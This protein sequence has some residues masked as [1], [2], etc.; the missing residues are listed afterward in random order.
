MTKEKLI[1]IIQRL[2]KTEIDLS[3]LLQLKKSELETMVACV[4]DRV[5]QVGK[6]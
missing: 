5:E 4:R 3:F 6:P 1:E 2:L